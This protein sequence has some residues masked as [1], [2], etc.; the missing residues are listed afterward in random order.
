MTI[1]FEKYHGAGNDF[2]IIDNRESQISL[3]AR[4]IKRM[5]ERHFGVGADGVIEIMQSDDS[6]FYM[7]YYNADGHVGTM[8]G[9]GGRCAAIFAYRHNISGAEMKFETT[10]G[11]HYANIINEDLVQLSMND[12]DSVHHKEDHYFIDTGSPHYVKFV[13]EINE[14][15]FISEA[16]NIRHNYREGGTNV[17]YVMEEKDHL[18]IRTFERGVEAETL[19]CGTGITAA[20]LALAYR[21]NLKPGPVGIKAQGGFLKVYFVEENNIFKNIWLEGPVSYVFKG[22]LQL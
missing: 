16:R 12:V 15:L 18:R 6:D 9:N 8:C 21:D 11:R 20:A 1:H 2:I 7:H 14:P 4:H 13:N 5:C 10:D 3:S 22:E 17:D 19:A